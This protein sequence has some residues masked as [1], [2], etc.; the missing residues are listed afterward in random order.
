MVPAVAGT[1]SSEVAREPTQ[2]QWLQPGGACP[3]ADDPLQERRSTSS[4]DALEIYV[5]SSCFSATEGWEARL[6]I[7][8]WRLTT[9]WR[10]PSRWTSE[11]LG[12]S[13]RALP[14][15]VG[16]AWCHNRTWHHLAEW[17]KGS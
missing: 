13:R 7:L 1:F 17:T 14:S 3:H 9:H 11:I 2:F 8:A 12:Q 16:A 10:S 5:L 15:P 6:D 4:T